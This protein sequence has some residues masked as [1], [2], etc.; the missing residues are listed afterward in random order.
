MSCRAPRLVDH[1]GSLADD[2]AVG[3]ASHDG[4][5]AFL[6]RGQGVGGAQTLADHPQRLV[7]DVGGLGVGEA[8]V[9]ATKF[10]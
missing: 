7:G 4:E 10:R 6:R 5:V 2:G 8:V 3:E 9:D 1:V